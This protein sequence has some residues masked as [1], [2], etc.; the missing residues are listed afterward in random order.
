MS[1]WLAQIAVSPHCTRIW[2]RGLLNAQSVHRDL[3]RLA[4]D[5]LGEQPRKTAGMLWRAEDS[6]HGLQLLVQMS[7]PPN[8]ERLQPDLAITA[9]QR[10]LTPLLDRL[11]TGMHVRYRISA[12]ATKRH[13]NSA[14]DKKGKLANLRGEAA[15]E[16]WFRRAEQSGLRCT[17][18]HTTSLP[19][20]CGTANAK[21]QHHAVRHAV[22]RFEGT[23]IVTY[24]EL[25]HT[26]VREGI[27]RARTYGCGLLS[28]G[29]I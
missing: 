8:L 22:T 28:L 29:P 12:N 26:A 16:W 18:V 2:S 19:D 11:H 27:G 3:M 1:A 6:P 24:P 13:G 17:T 25:L 23:G 7:T 10:D 14:P 5:N 21:R 20:V 4:E 15:E 9:R